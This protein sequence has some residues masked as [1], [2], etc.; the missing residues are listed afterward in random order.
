MN[1]GNCRFKNGGSKS[2]ST[3]EEPTSTDGL[4]NVIILLFVKDEISYKM[5]P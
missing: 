3:L 4:K 5:S 1:D 2:G